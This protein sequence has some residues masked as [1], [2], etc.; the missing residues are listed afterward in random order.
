M[1]EPEKLKNFIP[2]DT[3]SEETLA[4]LAKRVEVMGYA[5]GAAIC[6]EGDTDDD[7]VYLLEGGA[8]LVSKGS[9]M[10]RVFHGG[11]PEAAFALAQG[12]PR[13]ASITAT[14]KA[15]VLRI[16]TSKLDRVVLLDEFTTTIPMFDDGDNPFKGDTQWLEEMTQSEAFK[17]LSREKLPAMLTK[18]ETVSVK[19][20]EVVFKQGD[21]GDYYYI[22]RSGIFNISRK[23]TQGKVEILDELTAGSV[24]GEESLISGRTRNASVVSMGN[25]ELMRLAKADFEALLK[26][27]LLSYVTMQ[28][29]ERMLGAGA[30]MLDVRSPQEFKTGTLSHTENLPV[31]QLRERMAE[32][33]PDI[34]YVLCCKLGIH[35]EIAAFL[36]SQR[37]FNVYVLKGGIDANK[38]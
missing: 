32:L 38:K 16:D 2:M 17:S 7:S 24:F 29:A 30:R 37:G 20:G 5:K 35:S 13:P 26:Q 11:T 28:E 15:T 23:N 22:V 25:G 10:T 33:D 8:E 14:T 3:L 19:R 1:I 12:R 9:T 4:R 27:P 18:L 6:L 34:S 21:R 31:A 36:M